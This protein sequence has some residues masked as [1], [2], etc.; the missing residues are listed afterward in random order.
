MR[1]VL[2]VGR[3]NRGKGLMNLVNAWSLVRED[4]WRVVIAGFDEEGCEA[5]LRARA[6]ELDMEG[7]FEFPGAVYGEAKERL[8]ASADLFVL[9]SLSENF[10]S[11]VIESL[12]Q[13]TPVI[14]TRETPW[15]ELPRSG[16]GWWVDVGVKPL[17]ETLKSAIALSDQERHAMGARGRDLVEKKYTWDAVV[18]KMIEGYEITLAMHKSK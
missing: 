14:A 9:P 4:G 2:Y 1:T 13:Q 10:G 5:E 11:V 15:D 17:A 18:K 6:K 3:I 16:C 7:D 12:A 8:M